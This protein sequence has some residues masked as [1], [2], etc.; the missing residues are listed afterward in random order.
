VRIP[1]EKVDDILAAA[2]IVEVIGDYVKLKKKGKYYVGLSPFQAEKSPSFTVSPHRQIFKDFSSGKG[3]S[4]VTFLMELEGYTY[5]EALKHLARKYN[6]E[7]EFEQTPELEAEQSRKESLAILNEFAAKFFENQLWNTEEGQRIGL[8]YFKQRGFTEATIRKFRLGY[9]PTRVDALYKTAKDEQFKNEFI[10]E[11][12]L[13]FKNDRG[14]W[15]DRF[16]SRVIFPILNPQGRIIAFAGRI[17]TSE[18]TLA[19]YINSPESALYLKS[20]VLFGLYHARQAIREK[21]EAF[22]CEGYTDVISLHQNGIQ[23]VV[24]SSGTALTPDQIRL[25]HRYAN[26]VTILYDGDP[27]G[28]KASLR[29][30]NLILEQGLDIKVL[31]LPD[32]HDPDSFVKSRSLTEFNSYIE[33]HSRDFI[34]FQIQALSASGDLTKP[35]TLALVVNEIATS[36]ASIPDNIKRTGYIRITSNRLNLPEENIAQSVHSK[37]SDKIKE[38]AKQF[39]N[40]ERIRDGE[41]QQSSSTVLPSTKEIKPTIPYDTEN[42]EKELIRLMLLYWHKSIEAPRTDFENIDNLEE[43]APSSRSFTIEDETWYEINVIEYLW[44]SLYDYTFKYSHLQELRKLILEA[45]YSFGSLE[46]WLSG[47]HEL[48]KQYQET[49][50]ELL[51]EPPEVS[52]HWSKYDIVVTKPDHQLRESLLSAIHHFIAKILDQRLA[53][54]RLEIKKAQLEKLEDIDLIRII[55]THVQLEKE[56][57]EHYKKFG[58]VITD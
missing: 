41:F 34:D 25:L 3:G 46:A 37:L 13:A 53:E 44:I 19:K 9:S 15:T 52:P 38:D 26:K 5:P 24:A 35:Q 10:E 29:G 11:S 57:Q 33:E 56:K 30:V 47:L 23:N 4:V 1:K 36:I 32:G 55:E 45:Y 42:Q 28:I 48:D 7:L 39:K 20:Q 17:L 18:K 21:E 58:T 27:A 12:G 6:I 49:I 54:S 22:L 40:Q 14:S 8:S 31:L 43:V 50:A 2:D 16:R 51:V